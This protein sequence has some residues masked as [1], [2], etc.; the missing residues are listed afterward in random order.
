MWH[1]IQTDGDPKEE[2][3]YLIAYRYKETNKLDYCTGEFFHDEN[4]WHWH[5]VFDDVEIIAW[6]EIEPFVL[7]NELK[8]DSEVGV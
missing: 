3:R 4:D 6:Q 7:P 8:N 1:Y 5:V 2:G